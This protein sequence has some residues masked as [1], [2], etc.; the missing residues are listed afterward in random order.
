MAPPLSYPKVPIADRLKWT[1]PSAEKMGLE[2]DEKWDGSRCRYC[3]IGVL[4]PWSWR[5]PRKCRV[6]KQEN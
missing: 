6:C 4:S 1:G 2:K 3:G 5:K